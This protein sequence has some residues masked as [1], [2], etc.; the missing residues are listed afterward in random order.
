MKNIKRFLSPILLDPW[1][2][3]KGFCM[4]GLWGLNPIAHVIFLERIT[5]SLE[6]RDEILFKDMLIYYVVFLVIYQMLNYFF[7]N[8][9]WVEIA[10]KTQ[11]NIHRYY[12]TKFIK[13]NNN[14]TETM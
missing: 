13:L 5:Y 12:I 14:K 11:K 8:R 6:I 3:I 10:E 2:Y 4:Y 7:R 9:G 1:L